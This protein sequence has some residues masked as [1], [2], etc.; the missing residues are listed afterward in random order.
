MP[1][2][3]LMASSG[4]D[5]AV[6]ALD[7]ANQAQR[8]LGDGFVQ[9]ESSQLLTQIS[10]GNAG[11]IWGL[12]AA[13]KVYQLV[14]SIPQPAAFAHLWHVSVGFDGTIWGLDDHE[15]I[16]RWVSGAWQKVPGNLDQ[17]SIGDANTIWGVYG[18]SGFWGGPGD[19]KRWNGTSWDAIP[20]PA[21]LRWVSVSQDLTVWAYTVDNRTLTY[22]GNNTWT[23]VAANGPSLWGI[24]GGPSGLAYG[25]DFLNLWQLTG[26]T[27]HRNRGIDSIGYV[28]FAGDGTLL[29]SSAWRPYRQTG[30]T[31]FTLVTGLGE[32]L[33]AIPLGAHSAYFN[34]VLS[35]RYS[36]WA[37]SRW[38][39]RTGTLANISVAS[40]GTMW[41][42]DSA[43]KV[44]QWS[45]GAWQ[46][47]PGTLARVSAGSASYVVGL[48]PQGNVQSWQNGAW[49]PITPP[50]T[51]RMIDVSIGADATLF[52]I[53]ANFDVY[54]RVPPLD[55]SKHNGLE[56]LQVDVADQFH[57]CGATPIDPASGKNTVWQG[58]AAQHQRPPA[59]T[60][61]YFSADIQ[62]SHH[63]RK[64]P[65]DPPR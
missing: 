14:D 18:P 45:G 26:G 8:F 21:R 11:N 34:E 65:R 28:G 58:A 12:D 38:L 9:D 16:F 42:V 37:G 25:W 40:D 1:N 53:A 19:A 61:E 35:H 62:S 4:I 57:V 5:G 2:S 52:V 36:S 31:N 48:D 49:V 27:W 13:G 46:T 17:L 10:V 23:T 24:A 39:E 33:D 3:Y 50:T 15:Q 47:R 64:P 41:G 6:W 32:V 7:S 44:Y 56:L 59:Q 29:V 22:N 30:Y 63:Y 51:G 60:P 55:W 43:N 54:S 20:T